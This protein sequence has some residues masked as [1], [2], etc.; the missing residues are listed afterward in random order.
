MLVN[1]KI[2]LAVFLILGLLATPAN[3]A[4]TESSHIDIV[5]TA[6]YEP[7]S[8]TFYVASGWSSSNDL[9]KAEIRDNE[10]GLVTYDRLYFALFEK[11]GQDMNGN[12]VTGERLYLE[13]DTLIPPEVN[14]HVNVTNWFE[15]KLP[16]LPKGN[17]MV[18][19]YYN[20]NLY[21]SAS[22]KTVNLDYY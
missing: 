19:L 21:L 9:L 7:N 4:A 5:H 18:F 20:G 22:S 16:N 12:G 15:H 1:S 2:F 3:V 8:N 6:N 13:S 11:G 17:Y 10:G 14:N